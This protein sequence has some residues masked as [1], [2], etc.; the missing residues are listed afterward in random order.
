MYQAVLI[1]L[2]KYLQV[3][4]GAYPRGEHQKCVLS[5]L[6]DLLVGIRLGWK[7]LPGKN[8]LAC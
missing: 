5:K 8:I 2:V 3:R 6:L 1:S 4:P 7:G